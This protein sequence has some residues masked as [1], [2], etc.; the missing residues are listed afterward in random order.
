MGKR[1]RLWRGPLLLLSTFSYN[2]TP[3][4][5]IVT[6]LLVVNRVWFVS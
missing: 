1:H 3:S 4:A 2:C 5:L 6:E